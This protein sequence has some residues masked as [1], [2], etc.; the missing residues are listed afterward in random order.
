MKRCESRGTTSPFS[1]L[2]LD[3]GD[4]QLHALVEIPLVPTVC[5]A[6]WAPEPVWTLW[7]REKSLPLPEIEP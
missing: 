1:T 6:E 5:E 7:R 2:A 3:G 4:C